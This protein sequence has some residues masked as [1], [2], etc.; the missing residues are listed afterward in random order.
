MN[1]LENTSTEALLVIQNNLLKGLG[2]VASH[3]EAG[4]FND[5]V[6]EGAAPPAQSGWL[7]LMM[8]LGVEDELESRILG[9]ERVLDLDLIKTL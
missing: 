5:H 2:L 1:G 8:L 3:L 4:T 6:K 7:T 9:F